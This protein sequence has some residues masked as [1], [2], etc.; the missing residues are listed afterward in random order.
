MG[1]IYSNTELIWHGN[2]LKLER[3]EVAQVVPDAKWPG[4][5]RVCLPDGRLTDMVNRTRA[6]DAALA[7][8]CASL[9]R[10]QDAQETPL[11]PVTGD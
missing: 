5:W 4:M 1:R 6:K 10:K 8:A 3:R 9:N 11:E 7:L 2:V